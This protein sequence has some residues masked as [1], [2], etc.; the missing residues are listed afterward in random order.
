[1]RSRTLF[2][3]LIVALSATVV[4]QNTGNVSFKFLWTTLSLAK[5][6]IILG[7]LAIGLIVGIMIVGPKTPNG[8]DNPDKNSEDEN[9]LR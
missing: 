5:S 8:G 4:L 6:T 3:L 1:M 2:I 7:A 9:Y